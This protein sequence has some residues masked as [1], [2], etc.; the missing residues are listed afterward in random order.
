M[1]TTIVQRAALGSL[2]GG[3][4]YMTFEDAVAEFPVEHFNTR[5]FNLEYSFWHLLEHI[6]ICNRDILDYIQSA[7]YHEL[8]FPNDLWP[9]RGDNTDEEGWGRTLAEIRQDMASLRALV[10]DGKSDLAELAL[11]AGGDSKPTLLREVL[12]IADHNAYHLGEF[13]ILRHLLNLWPASHDA[14]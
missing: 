1:D 8:E 12:V 5:P 10:A 14:V 13:S 4:A 7:T 9:D 6:R 3:Q 11:N 2:D